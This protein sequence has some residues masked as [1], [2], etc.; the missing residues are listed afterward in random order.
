[1]NVDP[2][3]SSLAGIVQ[4][5]ESVRALILDEQN[6]VLLVRFYWDGFENPDGFWANPGGGVEPGESRLEAMQRE[7]KE[8]IGLAVDHLGP[9]VWTKTALFE[10]NG[11]DGQIDHIHL[12][13]TDRFD[14]E[15]ELSK[16]QLK[17][18]GLLELRWWSPEELQGLGLTFAPRSLPELLTRL[19]EEGAPEAP[20]ELDGF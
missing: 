2:P 12:Y 3:P 6:H 4:L 5:R 20:I 17:A 18:E 11:W 13:R 9:E 7:L 10:M 1:M 15:P 16:E 14:P 8:E 19:R